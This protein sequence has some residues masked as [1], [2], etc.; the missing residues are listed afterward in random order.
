MP[1]GFDRDLDVE[2]RALGDMRRRHGGE[3]DQLL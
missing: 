3:R 1:D 2:R